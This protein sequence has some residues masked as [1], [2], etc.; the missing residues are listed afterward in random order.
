MKVSIRDSKPNCGS[1][2]V[3]VIFDIHGVDRPH[4]IHCK[5]HAIPDQ[6][7]KKKQTNIYTR[8]KKR[9]RFELADHEMMS[10]GQQQTMPSCAS[11]SHPVADPA[12]VSPFPCGF[13]LQTQ[14]LWSCYAGATY[15]GPSPGALWDHQ[16]D[17]F[18]YGSAGY[19]S[20]SS[21]NV[22]A[23]SQSP[24]GPSPPPGL[25]PPGGLPPLPCTLAG[26]TPAGLGPRRRPS[27]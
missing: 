1:G 8:A 21:I 3:Q 22:Y 2:T 25:P 13:M 5:A 27:R 14:G 15:Q 11:W 4:I 24:R 23:A 9:L 10:S 17:Y 20:S 12:F 7:M 26:S 19:A 16:E 6:V 18:S